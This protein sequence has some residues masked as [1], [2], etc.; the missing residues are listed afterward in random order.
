[1]IGREYALS[2][3]PS[4]DSKWNCE[5]AKL[6]VQRSKIIFSFKIKTEV[7]ALLLFLTHPFIREYSLSIFLISHSST[8]WAIVPGAKNRRSSEIWTAKF[9]T[10]QRVMS[11]K[12]EFL[13]FF[14]LTHAIL[15][16]RCFKTVDTE[17]PFEVITNPCYFIAIMNETNFYRSVVSKCLDHSD[18]SILT[19]PRFCIYSSF[20]SSP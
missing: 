5:I 13:K 20:R 2:N 11:G 14:T 1:M 19:F 7:S 8:F 3:K 10:P 15:Q 18:V 17:I 16:K 4:H 9:Y 12:Y 6:Q